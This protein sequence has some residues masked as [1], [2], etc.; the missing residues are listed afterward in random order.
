MAAPSPRSRRVA[1]VRSPRPDVAAHLLEAVLL[2]LLVAA[3]AGASGRL[4][5]DPGGA[6]SRLEQLGFAVQLFAQE[7]VA[8]RSRGGVEPD[9]RFGS[10]GSYDLFGL[11]DLEELAGLPGLG[12]LVHAKGQYDSNVNDDVGSLSD[13]IDDADFDEPIYLSELWLR[14]VLLRDRVRLRIGFLEQQTLFDR[15][16]YA[17]S[18]DRQFA[19]SFLDNNPV[20]PLPNALGIALVVEPRPG[21]ELALGAADAD[22]RPRNAGFAS[23]FDG[24]DSLNGYVE[25][26]LRAAFDSAAGALPGTYRL[27]GF[28]DGRR[29]AR[30]GRQGRGDRG[31]YGAYLSFDQAL[32]PPADAGTADGLGVFGRFGVADEDVNLIA[33]FWSLGLQYVGA[34]PGRPL[35]VLGLGLSQAIGSDRYHDEIDSDFEQETGFE[36]YYR[37]ALRPWLHL[38]PDFQYVARPGASSA[39]RDAVVWMLRVRASF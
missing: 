32:S 17:E 19:A 9:D 26:S 12:M 37:I 6:R 27:G 28:R 1:H 34:V 31:H 5:G 33:W 39:G 4:L 2:G 30:F 3:P 8:V 36:L 38:T 25:L 29:K 23:A 10:S 22:N 24:V 15:N 16:A 14:Q 7:F 21:L 35:D 13:V 20:V 11:A 18:E